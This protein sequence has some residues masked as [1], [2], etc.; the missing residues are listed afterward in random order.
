MISRSW[1]YLRSVS[2]ISRMMLF[3]AASCAFAGAMDD[4][5]SDVGESEGSCGEARDGGEGGDWSKASGGR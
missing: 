4:V 1:T 2:T 5:A 3:R